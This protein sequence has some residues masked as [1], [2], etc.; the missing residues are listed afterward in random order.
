[1]LDELSDVRQLSAGFK[2]A[3]FA[4]S[5]GLRTADGAHRITGAH[6][7]QITVALHLGGGRMPGC[8]DGAPAAELVAAC[9]RHRVVQQILHTRTRIRPI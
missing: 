3:H 1:M 5:H 9:Q 4:L 8:A 6:E 7:L 2:D